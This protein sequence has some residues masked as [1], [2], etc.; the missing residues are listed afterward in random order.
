MTPRGCALRPCGE[1]QASGASGGLGKQSLAS[2]M[3][4]WLWDFELGDPSE[5]ASWS[6]SVLVC[7]KGGTPPSGRSPASPV[8]GGGGGGS[9]RFRGRWCVDEAAGFAVPGTVSHASSAH[10]TTKSRLPVRCSARQPEEAEGGAVALS[11]GDGLDA[12]GRPL[13]WGKG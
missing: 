4:F 13:A 12:G 7:G 9:G 11:L 5:L 3:A 6:P 2:D 10:G 8:A 1:V